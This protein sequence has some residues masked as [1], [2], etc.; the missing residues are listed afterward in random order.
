MFEELLVSLDILV[1]SDIQIMT[2]PPKADIL[3]IRRETPQWTKEQ[4]MRLPDGIQDTKADHIL[5]EFKF[6]ESVNIDA[7][8]QTLA[9]DTFFKRTNKSLRS[10][11]IQTFILTSK[12]PIKETMKMFE[13]TQTTK[14]GVY[15]STNILLKKIHLIVINELSDAPH[16]D[17]VKCFSSLKRLRQK[18]FKQITKVGR[19]GLSVKFYYFINGLIK[20][21]NRKK[22]EGLKMENEITSDLLMEIGKDMYDTMLSGLSSDDCIERFGAKRDSFKV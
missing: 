20:L 11:Q 4:L 10:D 6:S 18:A 22:Q 16:N 3:L 17:F 19:K 2:N 13:Y 5:I 8:N 12:T 14:Q 7:I 15:H 21:L 1:S 9:Y